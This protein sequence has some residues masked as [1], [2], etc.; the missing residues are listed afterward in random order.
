MGRKIGTQ[1]KN[2]GNHMSEHNVN[3]GHDHSN[4]LKR[5]SK[6]KGQ[7]EGIERMLLDG[8]YCPDVIQQ[9]KSVR[10]ALMGLQAVLLEGHL[11]GCVKHAFTANDPRESSQKIN[12]LLELMK[13]Q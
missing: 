10:S 2:L 7:M 13:G 3:H 8:R 6:I 12:E 1:Q 4:E 9:I 5:I 11:K